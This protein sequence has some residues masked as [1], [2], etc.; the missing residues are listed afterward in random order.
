MAMTFRE[1]RTVATRA[2]PVCAIGVQALVDYDAFVG[3]EAR[4]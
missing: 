3:M 1:V 4:S 2:C